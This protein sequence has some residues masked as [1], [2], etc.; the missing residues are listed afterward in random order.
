MRHTFTK[1]LSDITSQIIPFVI[2]HKLAILLVVLALIIAGTNAVHDEYPDEFDSIV[3]GKFIARLRLP[4]TGFFTHHNPGAYVL[5]AVIY[6]FSGASFVRFRFLYQLAMVIFLFGSQWWLWRH[7]KSKLFLKI[8]YSISLVFLLAASYT[9]SHMLLADSL[10][11]LLIIPVYTAILYGFISK[12]ALN[13][14]Q[15]TFTTLLLFFVWWTSWTFV[16]LS[17][18]LY[19]PLLFLYLRKN[20][21]IKKSLMS[22]GIILAPFILFGMY[23]LITGSLSQY[24]FQAIDFNRKYYVYTR[25]DF[26]TSN[27]IRFIAI[28]LHAFMFDFFTGMIDLKGLDFAFPYTSALLLSNLVFFIVLVSRGHYTLAAISFFALVFTTFRT[29]PL[30]KGDTDYQ[31]AVYQALSY[32]HGITSLWWIAQLESKQKIKGVIRDTLRVSWLLLAIAWLFLISFLFVRWFDKAYLRYMGTMPL[33]YDRPALQTAID[34]LVEPDATFMIYPFAFKDYFFTK[35]NNLATNYHIL[36]PAMDKSS[37]IQERIID[38]LQSSMPEVIVFDR[39]YYIFGGEPGRFLD[40]FLQENYQTLEQ[41][42][43]SEGDTFESRVDYDYYDLYSDFFFRNDV[44]NE[45]IEKMKQLG[46]I[47]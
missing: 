39:Q 16:F 2:K 6:L 33:V 34:D 21:S 30:T 14:K 5:A 46:W 25:E 7:E 38:D 17:A 20:F 4:Y 44:T 32:I 1:K 22:L 27:P 10:A 28:T 37:Q 35:N 40:P 3:G 42:A 11:G 13:T 19:L 43:N 18:W 26:T 12:K 23:L 31:A 15:F 8:G 24:Y 29:G 36:I 41:V 9:W 45:Y 47:E